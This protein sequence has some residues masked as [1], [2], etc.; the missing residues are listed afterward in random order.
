MSQLT[1]QQFLGDGCRFMKQRIRVFAGL[2]LLIISVAAIGSRA[3]RVQASG[4]E[5][6]PPSVIV[7]GDDPAG[8]L[9]ADLYPGQGQT[10]VNGRTEEC[11][12]IIKP[13]MPPVDGTRKCVNGKWGQCIPNSGG[14]PPP[15]PPPVTGTVIPKYYILTVVYAPPGTNGG[16]AS[17]SVNYGS[18]STAGSTVSSSHSFKQSNTLSVTASAGLLGTKEDSA[19]FS[20]GLSNNQTDSQSV[21]IK[22]TQGTE[23]NDVGPG[24]DG[25]DHDH[26]LIYLWLNPSVQITLFPTVGGTGVSKVTWKPLTTGATVITYLYVGW[27]RNPSTIPPGELQL[28]QRYGITPADYPQILKADPFWFKRPIESIQ[29]I[30]APDPKRFEQL[31]TT[32]PYEPPFSATDPVPTYKFTSTY[33]KTTSS[34]STSQTETTVGLTLQTSGGFLSLFTLT[35]KDQATW[36]WTN[37]DTTSNSTGSTES[38]TVTVGGP[39]FGYTGP[40]EMAVYYDK[41][42]KT[43]LF[44]PVTGNPVLTGAVTLRAGQ[45]RF[46]Q[47]VIVESNGAKYRT[48]TNA[49]G[50][51]KVYGNVTGPVKVTVGGTTKNLPQLPPDRKMNI[52]MP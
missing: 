12:R 40:T 2:V 30:G 22:K 9:I 21:D 27:L 48:F 44:F 8:D 38:A 28:L 51:Y 15:P 1:E 43:F 35:I 6:M 24:Q 25:V 26:D 14:N 10:C 7:S 37:T 32:F 17:S 29:Q 47:E 13:G 23:I 39:A 3:H 49:K 34:T 16:K 5:E 4:L 11:I 19:G 45:A 52:A 42:Y 46:G 20:F 36:T 50:E 33:A 31:F 41:I 18:G